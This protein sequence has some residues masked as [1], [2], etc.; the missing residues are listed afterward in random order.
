M[1]TAR[2]TLPRAITLI[3]FFVFGPIAVAVEAWRGD[4]QARAFT[5]VGVAFLALLALALL[6]LHLYAGFTI[7]AWTLLIAATVAYACMVVLLASGFYYMDGIGGIKRPDGAPLTVVGAAYL[8]VATL[9]GLGY[10]DRYPVSDPAKLMA[11]LGVLTGLGCAVFIFS[12]LAGA[13]RGDSSAPKDT[14]A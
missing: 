13:L 9:T 8:S 11:M 2:L 7:G 4:S 10:A 6:F 12:L 5:L 14:G 1:P 3:I